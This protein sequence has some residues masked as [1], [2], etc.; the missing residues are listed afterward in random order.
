MEISKVK[1]LNDLESENAKLKK[2]LDDATR[3]MEALK[4]LV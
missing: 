3:D 1:R 4:V 2:L